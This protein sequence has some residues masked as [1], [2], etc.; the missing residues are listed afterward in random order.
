MSEEKDEF[1]EILT[2]LRT[3]PKF[4][5]VLLEQKREF[6]DALALLNK[7]PKDEQPDHVAVLLYIA[8]QY[9]DLAGESI[10]GNLE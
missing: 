5:R 6:A 8:A 2:E 1:E 3:L 4:Q 9:E 10:L 7:C